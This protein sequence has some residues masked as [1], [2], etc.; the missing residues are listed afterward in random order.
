M[1]L[2]LG[3]GHIAV[4]MEGWTQGRK[5]RRGLVVTEHLLH[6]RGQARSL[7]IYPQSP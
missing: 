7:T 1:L 6:S 5:R 3:R 2:G 4:L